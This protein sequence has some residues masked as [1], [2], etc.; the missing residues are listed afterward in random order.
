MYYTRLSRLDDFVYYFAILCNNLTGLGKS[1]YYAKIKSALNVMQFIFHLYIFPF[2]STKRIIW[3]DSVSNWIRHSKLFQYL[4]YGYY[5]LYLIIFSLNCGA[6]SATLSFLSRGRESLCRCGADGCAT[7]ESFCANRSGCPAV[8]KVR[9]DNI[10]NIKNI[11]NF[12]K[13]C[14]IRCIELLKIL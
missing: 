13:F 6:D 3:I 12:Y 8:T 11:S 7:A 1:K 2:H 4:K 14:F 5:F 10:Y 9:F